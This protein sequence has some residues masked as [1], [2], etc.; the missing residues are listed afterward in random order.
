MTPT[1]WILLV[2]LGTWATLDVTAFGQFMVS[3]AFVSGTLAGAILGDPVTGA[4][5]GGI[6]ELLFLGNLAVGGVVLPE[7]G[8]A[9]VPAVALA[10]SAPGVPGGLI[11]LGVAFGIV[12]AWA[13][14]RSTVQQRRLNDRVTARAW[15]RGGG[16]GELARAQF[17][18]L[19][20]EGLRGTTLTAIGL[21][22]VTLV[23]IVGIIEFA[24]ARWP[25]PTPETIA[26]LVLAGLLGLGSLSG[27]AASRSGRPGAHR[28]LILLGAGLLVGVALAL[29]ITPAGSAS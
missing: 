22:V 4:I 20:L 12:W 3:R 15:A 26:L 13:G 16:E 25:L 5:V 23:G 6:L 9:A 2:G 18:A 17:T 11:A 7:P 21:G 8:P 28:P 10:L 24:G 27:M 14:G 1:E 19:G 29:A